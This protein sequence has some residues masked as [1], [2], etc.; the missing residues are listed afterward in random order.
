MTFTPDTYGFDAVLR[1]IA[2]V[3]L[4]GE[5]WT[6]SGWPAEQSIFERHGSIL[7]DFGDGKGTVWPYQLTADDYFAG[8]WYRC[9]GVPDG[10]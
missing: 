9:G 5:R 8:D 1:S 2:A 6:R 3:P 10:G 4:S 7:M